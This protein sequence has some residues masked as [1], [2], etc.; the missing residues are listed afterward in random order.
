[1]VQF[2]SQRVGSCH[3]RKFLCAKGQGKLLNRSRIGKCSDHHQFIMKDGRMKNHGARIM[4]ALQPL[5]VVLYTLQS[6]LVTRMCCGKSSV[7]FETSNRH[8]FNVPW[9]DSTSL[10]LCY[11]LWMFCMH[12]IHQSSICIVFNSSRKP[13][14]IKTTALRPYLI[15]RT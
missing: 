1:M 5:S 13:R 2:C 15:H 8:E 6:V 12:S 14:L 3:K 11:K 4:Y 9:H 7:H 10:P